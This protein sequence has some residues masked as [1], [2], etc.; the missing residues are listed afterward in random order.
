MEVA[1]QSRVARPNET[2]RNEKTNLDETNP[3][4]SLVRK[5]FLRLAE[6]V[7]DVVA[8]RTVANFMCLYKWMAGA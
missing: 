4:N 8:S 7:A 2:K 3:P 1:S 5:Q 6:I